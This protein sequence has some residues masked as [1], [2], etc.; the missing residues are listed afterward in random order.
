MPLKPELQRVGYMLEGD[1]IDWDDWIDTH[2]PKKNKN[3][4]FFG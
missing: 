1:Q 2:A 3:F 4:F